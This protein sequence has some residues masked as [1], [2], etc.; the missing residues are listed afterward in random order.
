MNRESN[1][2]IGDILEINSDIIRQ[3]VESKSPKF[4]TGIKERHYRHRLEKLI[5]RFNKDKLILDKTNIQELLVYLYT[6]NESQYS[7]ITNIKMSSQFGV[8]VIVAD[9]TIDPDISYIKDIKYIINISSKEDFMT[10]LMIIH[11]AEGTVLT[12]SLKLHNLSYFDIDGEL[13]IGV[14]KL[15]DTLLNLLERFLLDYLDR[16][17]KNK[18]YMKEVR[19]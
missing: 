6:Y 13:Q 8:D 2:I 19:K 18:G 4:I 10:I 7:V 16:F 12:N 17:K 14:S 15:N 1:R 3:R 9:L 11:R 5:K